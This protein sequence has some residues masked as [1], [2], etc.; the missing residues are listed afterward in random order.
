MDRTFHVSY[1]Q[2]FLNGNYYPVEKAREMLTYPGDKPILDN[3]WEIYRKSL[4]R[5]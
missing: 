5:A 2:G 1:D 3:A 4:K